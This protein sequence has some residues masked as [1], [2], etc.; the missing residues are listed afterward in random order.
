MLSL[1]ILLVLLV[2]IFRGVVAATT[3]LL[4]GVLSILGGFIVT[5][6]LTGVTEVS[7]FA[8]NV[9]TMLGLGMGIDY[10]LFMVSRFREEM[11]GGLTPTEAVGR[12]MRTAGR[13]VIVSGLTVALALSSL[14]LFP[15]GFLRSMGW[16]GMAAVLV[17]MVAALTALPALLAVFGRRINALPL[18]RRR[19]R[20]PPPAKASRPGQG[21]RAAGR[22]PGLGRPRPE[23]HAPAGALPGRGAGRARRA[24]RRPRALPEPRRAA[25]LHNQSNGWRG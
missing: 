23:R 6:L 13:T 22:R 5:R 7:V 3:P 12:T 18:R 17:A 20:R 11:D 15:M 9:I 4:V 21:P 8:V 16:G 14:L 19:R 10:A 1:P 25:S 2:F 24:G